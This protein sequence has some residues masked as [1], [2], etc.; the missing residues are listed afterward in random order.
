MNFRT[1]L[2]VYKFSFSWELGKAGN[3]KQ[4]PSN[5]D[6]HPMPLHNKSKFNIKPGG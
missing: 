1:D 5:S 6:A 2:R 3:N 4:Q